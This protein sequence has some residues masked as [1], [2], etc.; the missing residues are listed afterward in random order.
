MHW[1]DATQSESVSAYIPVL[2]QARVDLQS[3]PDSKDQASLSRPFQEL[4]V[5]VGI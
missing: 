5:H 3:D 4:P 2:D 1:P